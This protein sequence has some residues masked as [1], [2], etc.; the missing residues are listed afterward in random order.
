MS[1]VG[2]KSNDLVRSV[3][4]KA[5]YYGNMTLRGERVGRELD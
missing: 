4:A 5:S 2:I 3:I 1:K